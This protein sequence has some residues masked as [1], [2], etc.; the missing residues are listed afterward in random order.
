M[1]FNASSAHAERRTP[2]RT[3][4]AMIGFIDLFADRCLREGGFDGFG[5]VNGRT[6]SP[7]MEEEHARFFAAH[8]MMNGNDI[9]AAFAQ[10]FEDGL[11]FFFEN[12]KVTVDNGVFVA[13]G[14]SGPGVD[15]HFFAGFAAAI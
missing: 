13:A 12:D 9:N 14:E 4:P 5:E 8:V 7:I 6:A 15:A 10:G 2:Q 1:S 3:I 11:K